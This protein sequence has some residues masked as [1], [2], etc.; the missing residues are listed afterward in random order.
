LEHTA[1]LRPHLAEVNPWLAGQ[2]L[3]FGGLRL[4]LELRTAEQ[5]RALG[6]GARNLGVTI[7]QRESLAGH[8]IRQRV[9]LVALLRGL[10]DA[11]ARSVL[12]HELGHAWLGVRQAG[13]LPG[14]QEEGFCELV[15]HRHLLSLPD[16]ACR[17]QARRISASTQ[18]VYSE[19]F[20]KVKRAAER[21][22]WPALLQAVVRPWREN[23]SGGLAAC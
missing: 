21:V 6:A 15:A 9:V 4:R 23:E 19:G 10:P 22:G 2:G 17:W 20:H 8:T 18:P 13:G 3:R 14:W 11:L 16:A 12:L 1:Q 7:R 5:M